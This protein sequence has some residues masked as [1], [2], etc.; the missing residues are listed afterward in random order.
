MMPRDLLTPADLFGR[1]ASPNISC[2]KCDSSV[3]THAPHGAMTLG[4][5]IGQLEYLAIT[6]P[7]CD[8]VGR[9][10]VRR[11]ALQY[12]RDGRLT[13]W[14]GLMTNDCPRKI[15]FGPADGC[16]GAVP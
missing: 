6:C 14:V 10:S 4:Y 2:V 11:L 8:R 1:V 5:L 13:D 12:G 16:G 3:G 15:S 9:Y 7:K